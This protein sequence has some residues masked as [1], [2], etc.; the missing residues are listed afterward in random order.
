[1]TVAADPAYDAMIAAAGLAGDPFGAQ[2]GEMLRAPEAQ[3]FRDG[4]GNG[5]RRELKRWRAAFR[6]VAPG[7]A[8]H[9]TALVERH[10]VFLSGL[11][12]APDGG[13]R[14]HRRRGRPSPAGG[15]TAG[16]LRAR[17]RPR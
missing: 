11:I 2:L 8:E 5:G 3:G 6:N 10:D 15:S 13:R 1:M 12:T 9:V 17:V 14:E 7:V 4:S 16:R